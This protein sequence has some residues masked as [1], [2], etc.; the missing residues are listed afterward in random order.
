VGVID[1]YVTAARGAKAAVAQLAAVK[2]I[3]IM[4]ALADF[5]SLGFPQREDADRRGAITPALITNDSNPCQPVHRL[6]GLP[7]LRNSIRLYVYQP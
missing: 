6:P 3:Q 7:L 4:H 2:L 5:H 1:H